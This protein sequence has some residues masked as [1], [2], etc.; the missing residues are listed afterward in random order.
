MRAIIRAS[1]SGS[2][3]RSGE[4][5][6]SSRDRVQFAGIDGDPA[7]LGRERPD[8]D[9]ELA[10]ERARDGAGGDPRRGLARGRALEHVAYVV[11]AVLERAGEV[12]M[13]RAG[14]G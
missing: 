1:A 6:A 9:P 8:L 7:D 3:Q 12:G 11:E 2:G 5:S 4:A 10:Q 14:R 13:A